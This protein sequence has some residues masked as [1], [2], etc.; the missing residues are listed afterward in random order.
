[1]ALAQQY[2]CLA[3]KVKIIRMLV[4]DLGLTKNRQLL[5]KNTVI[6]EKMTNVNKILTQIIDLLYWN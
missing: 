6:L 4:K 3:N 1:M 5:D 2:A